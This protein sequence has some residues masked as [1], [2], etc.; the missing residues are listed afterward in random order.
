MYG[1]QGEWRR[2]CFDQAVTTFGLALE[3]ELD[4]IKGK[5]EKAINTKRGRVLAQWLDQ[6]LKFREPQATSTQTSPT[7]GDDHEPYGSDSGGD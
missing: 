5:N 1:I 2:F 3:A 7:A 4:S 6:P